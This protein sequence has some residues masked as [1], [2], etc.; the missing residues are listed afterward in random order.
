MRSRNQTLHE[1]KSCNSSKKSNILHNIF[2][3]FQQ[4]IGDYAMSPWIVFAIVFI[5]YMVVYIPNTRKNTPEEIQ[6]KL[7]ALVP[8]GS[9]RSSKPFAEL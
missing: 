9:T 7:G 3:A 8:S 2:F 6:A 1:E 5:I 4:G